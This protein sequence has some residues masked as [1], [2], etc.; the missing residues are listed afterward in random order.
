MFHANVECLE[1]LKEKKS[2]KEMEDIDE[3]DK[4]LNSDLSSDSA[5][6][7]HANSNSGLYCTG[8]HFFGEIP[9]PPP[10]LLI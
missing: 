8:E 7:K 3:I 9:E 1:L 10:D 4:L 5:N 2:E 6:K